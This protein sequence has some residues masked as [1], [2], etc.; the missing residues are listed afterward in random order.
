MI[1]LNFRL[2]M[3]F[4]MIMIRLFVYPHLFHHYNIKGWLV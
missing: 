3:M 4:Y 2:D 1:M